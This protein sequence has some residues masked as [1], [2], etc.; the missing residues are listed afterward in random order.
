MYTLHTYMMGDR[1]R[2]R[3]Y[4]QAILHLPSQFPYGGRLD[5]DDDDDE[6]MILYTRLFMPSNLFHVD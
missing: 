3:G 6:A 5:C 4:F 1:G 2:E